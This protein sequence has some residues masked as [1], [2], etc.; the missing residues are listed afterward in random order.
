MEHV[1]ARV[2][3]SLLTLDSTVRFA[4]N[5]DLWTVTFTGNVSNV[6]ITT[7]GYVCLSVGLSF[8]QSLCRSV[9]RSV[10]RSDCLSVCLP[11]F[12]S[13]FMLG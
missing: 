3:V 10:C 2:P 11:A 12:L 6:S 8:C 7:Q 1:S 5:V 13:V 4:R 9:C